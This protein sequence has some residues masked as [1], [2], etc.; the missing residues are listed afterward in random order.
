MTLSFHPTRAAAAVALAGALAAGAGCRS[1]HDNPGREIVP[2][3]VPRE[4][5]KMSLPDYR[6][7]PPDILTL[8]AIRAIPKPPYLVQP[9]DVLFVQ[10]PAAIPGDPPNSG[11]LPVDPDGTIDLGADYGGPIPV[12]GLTVPQIREALAQR[13][14][15]VTKRKPE[16]A[17]KPTE[18][19]VNLVQS[20]AAQQIGGP[21]LVRPDG[22]ISLSTYGSVRVAG[23]TIPEVRRAVE[24]KLA[25][26]L[27]DPV[28][29]V[30]VQNYNSKL[31]YVIF[32]GLGAGQTVYRLPVTGN[33]NVLDVIA[34]VNGMT[35]VSDHNRVWVAR[36]A[37]AGHGHTILPVDWRAVTECGDTA[38]NY[39][40]MP[41]DR[42]FVGANPM[43]GVDARM[44]RLFAPVERVFGITLLGTSVYRNIAFANRGF[45]GGFGG[46]GF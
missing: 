26:Y 32:D 6:V 34:Q 36:P 39:Q 11:N 30:D 20:Q 29:A 19:T 3:D 22:T 44:A 25:E 37:P 43:M 8:N 2:A 27:L 13:V 42:V 4:L 45:G 28:V 21:H 23:L 31:I 33:D 35:A 9:L 38:T 10:L 16:A 15:E 1:V 12:A 24:A 40:L 7:E 41:G 17:V 46:F 14:T 18:V 5:A